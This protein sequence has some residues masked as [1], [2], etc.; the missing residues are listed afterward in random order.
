MNAELGESKREYVGFIRIAGQPE[1][2]LR[3]MA[4]SSS[5]ARAIVIEQYGEG[6]VISVWN[7]EDARRPR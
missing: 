1:I 2:Q 3:L 5:E 6:H 4:S 7:E